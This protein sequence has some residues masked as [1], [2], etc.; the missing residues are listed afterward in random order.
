M[1]DRP[2]REQRP[3]YNR[4]MRLVDTRIFTRDIELLRNS[5]VDILE[6]TYEN[7][8]ELEDGNVNADEIPSPLHQ[9]MMKYELPL[10]MEEFFYH[11]VKHDA[12]D[13][14]KLRY[15]VYLVDDRA[16]EASGDSED[17]TQNYHAYL[18][19]SDHNRYIR[20]TLAVPV[21][22]TTTQI[23]NAISQHKQFIKDRQTEAN[24][25]TPIPR[26][27]SEFYIERDREILG[28]Y[29]QGLKP[30]AIERRLSGKF[31][32]LTAPMISSIVSRRRK[33]QR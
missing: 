28:L 20:V 32:I 6:S 11:F 9:V 31:G 25:G 1:P 24:N 27:R 15:G 30:R 13:L 33:Q 7:V 5:D 8:E 12:I 21:N 18:E 17:M 23:T 26:I 2:V 16:M 10:I 29:E 14:T 22:A 19:D 4:F 3:F